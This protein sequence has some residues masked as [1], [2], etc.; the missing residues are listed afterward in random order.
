MNVEKNNLVIKKENIV[1]GLKAKNMNDVI[2]IL[3]KSLYESKDIENIGKFKEAVYKR[4]TEI[5]TSIG[6]GVAIPHGK[7]SIVN[8]ST[9][10]LGVLDSYI[11]WGGKTEDKVKFVFLIAIKDGDEPEK[12]LRILANLSANLMDDNFVSEFKTAKNE[13]EIFNVINIINNKEENI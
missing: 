10:A 2:D 7:S 6:K 3:S 12:H 5:S 9:V 11:P 8:S 4:E 13:D 1:Y